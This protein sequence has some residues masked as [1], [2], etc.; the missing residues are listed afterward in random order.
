[1]FCLAQQPRA[2]DCAQ[3]G[4]KPT[5]PVPSPFAAQTSETSHEAR[6]GS[7]DRHRSSE[8]H[9]SEVMLSRY[10]GRFFKK[11]TEENQ[12]KTHED[13]SFEAAQNHPYLC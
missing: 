7:I 4:Y 10:H 11:K 6:L 12:E 8:V 3:I 9:H 5:F 13:P 1:M 2:A